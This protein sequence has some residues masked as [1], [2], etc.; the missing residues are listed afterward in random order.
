[1]TKY[2]TTLMQ[3]LELLQ[4]GLDRHT[5]DYQYDDVDGTHVLCEK[6]E[7]SP[8]VPA[9]SFGRLWDILHD[10]GRMFYEYPTTLSAEKV[11]ESLIEAVK[12]L[13][14]HRQHSR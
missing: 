12:R 9:W 8:V 2:V 1:M 11:M 6:A 5:A 3:S 4:A 14:N 10:S 13:H 7:E